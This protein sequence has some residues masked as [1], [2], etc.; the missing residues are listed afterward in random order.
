MFQ[1]LNLQTNEFVFDSENRLAQFESGQIAAE[2]ARELTEKTAIKHQPRRMIDQSANWIQREQA[3]IDSGF[4]TVPTWIDKFKDQV[5]IPPNL[6]VHVSKLDSSKIAFTQTPEKG[7]ADIQTQI[8]VG[9]FLQDYCEIKESPEQNK[10]V[11]IQQIA[12]DHATTYAPQEFKIATSAD[13]I[14]KIYENG[15]NSCMSHQASDYESSCHPVRVYG[16]S[17]LSLAYLFDVENEKATAR[18]LIW[19]TKRVHGRIYGDIERLKNAL[20]TAGYSE[21]RFNGARIRRII[22]QDNNVLVL[23]YLDGVQGVIT[24]DDDYLMISRDAEIEACNTNGLQTIGRWCECCESNETGDF[25]TVYT[26]RRSSQEWCEHCADHHATWCTRSDELVSDSC[27]TIVDGDP[28]AEWIA[29]DEACYCEFE[30]AYTFENCVSVIIDDRG[31]DATWSKSAFDDH[32]FVCRIDGERYCQ[33]LG[34]T[35]DGIDAPR[36]RMNEIE[37]SAQ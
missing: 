20:E 19:Q 36:A 24:H 21:G 5:T 12:L 27:I 37:E 2:F 13:E 15:P 31:N 29:E 8:K 26:S 18:A 22:C 14:Q 4:Y 6:F 28:V 25:R 34:V 33:S 30:E 10:S 9:V 17:D 7:S 16:D 32:G 35:D 3:R 1:I 23:P 11:L